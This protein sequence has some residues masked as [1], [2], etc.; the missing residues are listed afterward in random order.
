MLRLYLGSAEAIQN[1]KKANST[2][3]AG[4]PTGI[5]DASCQHGSS[6]KREKFVGEQSRGNHASTLAEVVVEHGTR[7]S[8]AL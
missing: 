5:L 8:T 2:V 6:G 7:I 3:G 4:R 1:E